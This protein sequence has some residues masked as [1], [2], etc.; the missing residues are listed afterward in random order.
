MLRGI[1]IW[2]FINA[3][4]R[5]PVEKM[6][7][8]VRA[9]GGNAYLTVADKPGHDAWSAALDGGILQWILAQRR[10]GPCWVPPGSEPWQWWHILI[11][12]RLVPD[13]C[14]A[15]VGFGTKAA[16][17]ALAY[18]RSRSSAIG[19]CRG[20]QPGKMQD[21]DPEPASQVVEQSVEDIRGVRLARDPSGLRS[22]KPGRGALG[23]RDARLCIPI[24][25]VMTAANL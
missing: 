8:A 20:E 6:V 21:G 24:L 10:S 11:L 22:I 16:L 19:R 9:T 14:A 15:G 3:G 17:V 18:C 13:Y 12:P 5:G 23:R 25:P 2:A 1:P 7:T 4:E